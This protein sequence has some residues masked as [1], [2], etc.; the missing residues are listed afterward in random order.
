MWHRLDAIIGAF[1]GTYVLLVS[2]AILVQDCV[3]RESSRTVGD[4]TVCVGPEASGDRSQ[5][6]GGACDSERESGH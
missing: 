1:C 2:C 6:G 5:S 3:L 4:I